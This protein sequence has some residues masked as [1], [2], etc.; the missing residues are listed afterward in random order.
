M[1]SRLEP[2]RGMLVAAPHQPFE[3]GA[4]VNS[5]QYTETKAPNATTHAVAETCS[6]DPEASPKAAAM[7]VTAATIAAM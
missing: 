5:G 1:I 6:M 3:E 4:R 7:R 2:L